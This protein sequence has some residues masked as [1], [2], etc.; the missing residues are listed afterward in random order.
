MRDE[1]K[2]ERQLVD[3]YKLEWAQWGKLDSLTKSHVWYVGGVG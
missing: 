1:G 2:Y 3:F